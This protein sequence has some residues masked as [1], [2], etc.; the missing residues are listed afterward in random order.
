MGLYGIVRY[1][2]RVRYGTVPSL[3]TFPCHDSINW[4]SQKHLDELRQI[5]YHIFRV[6]FDC[7]TSEMI[8]LSIFIHI[9]F[10]DE[11]LHLERE[12][13]FTFYLPAV[14]GG[15]HYGLVG[16]VFAFWIQVSAVSQKPLGSF[17]SSTSMFSLNF[18]K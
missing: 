10:L 14:F 12:P 15:G 6:L 1:G 7:Q 18:Y 8:P 17:I 11:L 9:I 13:I 5:L 16:P 4:H 2:T 3:E